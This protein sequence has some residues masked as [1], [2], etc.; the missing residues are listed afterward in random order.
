[1][2][3]D[4][5][6]NRDFLN[7]RFIADIA[8][9]MI[10]QA[11]GRPLSMGVSG[12]WGVGKSSMMKLLAESLKQRSDEKFLFVEFNAWLYQGYDDTR[13]ALM[14]IIARAILERAKSDKGAV[15]ETVEKA[16]GLLKRVN[17]FRVASTGITTA[18]SLAMG[19]P[20]V[21]L[22]GDGIAAVKNLTDGS[23]NQADIDSAS[24]VVKGTVSGAKGLY[25]EK[26]APEPETP[27]Q[28]IHDF[29]K[30]LHETLESLD[31]TLVVLIDDL[32]RCLPPTAIST[33]EA[34]R[35]F[36]FLERTAFIIAAD[37]KMIRQAV[38]SH[39]KNVDIDE[40]LVTNYFDKLIQVP[41]RVPAL[42]TQDV[43]AYLMMLFIENSALERDEKD[44][45]R[46]HVCKQLGETW[47]GKRVD[48]AFVASLIK[49]C[50]PEL[51]SKLD[52]AD[53]IAPIL[54][55]SSKIAGNPRLIKRFLNTLSLR[56][57]IARSQNVGV[58]ETALAKM[59]LFERCGSGKAYTELLSAIN[60]SGDGKASFLAPLET[61]VSKDPNS[62]NL[63]GEWN[64]DF[65][66]EWLGLQ[67]PLADIDL[68]GVAFVSRE[69]MPIITAA[70]RLSS[71][72][73]EIL[74][75]LN[76]LSTGMSN[77]LADK[78]K[79]LPVSEVAIITDRLL[80]KARSANQWGTPPILFGLLTIAH[81]DG[82]H[83]QLIARFMQGIPSAQIT[84]SLIPLLADKQWAKPILSVWAGASGVSDP[85]KKAIASA[86]KRKDK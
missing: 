17:W 35:L 45:I 86:S 84:A 64:N 29:R 60:E 13:A 44:E 63:D 19:L 27:P 46:T 52:L 21:G 69:H 41:I 58:D 20:P 9:E 39:F 22:I 71:E 82:E 70:D 3:S 12:S 48:R 43:R 23:I 42:G 50:P 30:E 40:D 74:E 59:L 36:L 75:A 56:M 53:R 55:T 7:F 78:L 61:A 8:A 72:G 57:T 80:A 76:K 66:R 31:I 25:E 16:K 83:R 81:L 4:N 6:T 47:T 65:V 26:P 54:T 10:A 14:E 32:D 34:M 62:V 1:M 5:E 2:W 38:R 73:A 15:A 11:D 18:A 28:A 33:L 67:P 79:P 68:R 37:D 51:A 24:K 77:A 49:N 85:V